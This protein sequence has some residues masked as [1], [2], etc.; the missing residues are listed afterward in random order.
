MLRCDMYPIEVVPSVRII[1]KNVFKM[2]R[3]FIED[4]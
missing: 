2:D 3:K 4:R 1:R